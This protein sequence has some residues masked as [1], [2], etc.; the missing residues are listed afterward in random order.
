MAFRHPAQWSEVAVAPIASEWVTGVDASDQ[1]SSDHGGDHPLDQPFVVARVFPLSSSGHDQVT[2]ET[3]RSLILSD[4]RDPTAADDPTIRL[5]FNQ[6]Y[7]DNQ[8]FEGQHLR[9]E[10]DGPEGTAVEE[11][12]AALD[13]QRKHLHM[14]SVVCSQQCFDINRADIESLFASLRL[15]P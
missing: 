7:G 13:P 8:G 11:H 2:V 1:P 5:L 3:L 10:L 15:R 9:F 4:G 14:V 6:D 12:L